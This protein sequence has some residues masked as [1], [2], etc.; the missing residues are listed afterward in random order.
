MNK[1][2]QCHLVTFEEARRMTLSK[3]GAIRLDHLFRTVTYDELQ[4]D[5]YDPEIVQGQLIV[6]F[7]FF[8]S[9]R[10]EVRRCDIHLVLCII[11]VL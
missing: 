5:H 3:F 4:T 1:H 8:F 2:C 9:Q 7:S 10:Q 11:D 6:S